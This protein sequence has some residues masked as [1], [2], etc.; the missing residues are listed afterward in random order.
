MDLV[1]T[2]LVINLNHVLNN[3]LSGRLWRSCSLTAITLHVR[4]ESYV[5]LRT[6]RPPVKTARPN[7][8]Y[9]I[10]RA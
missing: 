9:E 10:F 5:N 8:G 7:L 3:N 6:P 1:M 4:T 2:M